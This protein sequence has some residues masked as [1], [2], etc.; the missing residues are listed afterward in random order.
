M[1]TSDHDVAS[2]LRG[3]ILLL[4]HAIDALRD[5]AAAEAGTLQLHRE[6]LDAGDNLG[7]P[8]T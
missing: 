7:L 2:V 3:E 5:L 8:A 4:H 6:F 1:L